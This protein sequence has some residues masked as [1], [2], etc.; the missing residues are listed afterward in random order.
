MSDTTIEARTAEDLQ[1]IDLLV[2]DLLAD[3]DHASL[4]TD[5]VAV[6]VQIASRAYELRRQLR[7]VTQDC[8]T[9][10][11]WVGVLCEDR[12]ALREDRERLQAAALRF[13]TELGL[14]TAA[15]TG[16]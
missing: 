4:Y 12:R 5:P 6:I 15:P 16:R 3:P 13:A 14:S 10:E 8:R 9:A 7:G 11:H 1:A 2:S